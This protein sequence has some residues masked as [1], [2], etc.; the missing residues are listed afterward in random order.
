MCQLLEFTYSLNDNK[1]GI[2]RII[3]F[4][5]LEKLHFQVI[6]KTFISQ[7]DANIQLF[8]EHSKYHQY[9]EVLFPLIFLSGAVYDRSFSTLC[10][11][12]P[13]HLLVIPMLQVKT[14][15][16]WLILTVCAI[17]VYLFS[18]GNKHQSYLPLLLGIEADNIFAK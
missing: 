7:N 5:K 3:I 8:V 1:R 4:R 18:F 12:W 13:K 11:P 15:T 9:V 14:L 10:C 17:A 2:L 6:K 16:Y